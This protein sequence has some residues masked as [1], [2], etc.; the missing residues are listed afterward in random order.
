MPIVI[1]LVDR[2]VLGIGMAIGANAGQRGVPV[3]GRDE[4]AVERVHVAG[5]RMDEAGLG[6]VALADEEFL[7][8]WPTFFILRGVM[9]D[10]ETS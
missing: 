10:R 8:G 7:E 3:V 5:V 4:A 6:I 2:V 1:R 9:S